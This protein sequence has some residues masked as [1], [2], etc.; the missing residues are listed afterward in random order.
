VLVT[1]Q[2]PRPVVP[3][4]QEAVAAGNIRDVDVG[5]QQLGKSAG[6]NSL[7]NVSFLNVHVPDGPQPEAVPDGS[8]GQE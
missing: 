1:P 8:V 6:G 2:K 4:L 3:T 7:P 5:Q